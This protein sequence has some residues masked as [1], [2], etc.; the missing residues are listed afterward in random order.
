MKKVLVVAGMTCAWLAVAYAWPVAPLSA[1]GQAPRFEI[2]PTWPKPLPEGWI[3]GRLGGV[4]IDGHDHVIV[5]NR[6]DITDIN[7]LRIELAE[8]GPESM[9]RQAM[10]R[11]K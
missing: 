5:T 9:H 7:G 10:N 4:C 8:L 3:T 2:D 11:W 6:R 1:Q